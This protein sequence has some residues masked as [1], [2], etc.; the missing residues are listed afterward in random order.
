MAKVIPSAFGG[1]FMVEM[2]VGAGRANNRGDVTLVQYLM[3]LWLETPGVAVY[4][5]KL[6]SA[7]NKKLDVDGIYG[8]KTGSRIKQFQRYLS[9]GINPVICD[10]RIDK[11]PGDWNSSVNG[12]KAYTIGQLNLEVCFHYCPVMIDF[13]ADI[14]LRNDFPPSLKRVVSEYMF[15]LEF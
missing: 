8:P 2:G 9:T 15:S 3:N 5:Q 13:V 4:R 10:G 1:V 14:S 6:G 12:T 11:V 7:N